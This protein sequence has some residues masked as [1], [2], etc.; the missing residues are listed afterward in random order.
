MMKKERV[1]R[2]VFFFTL[3]VLFMCAAVSC[4]E[5]YNPS[6]HES[7]PSPP[8]IVGVEPAD[9]SEN[10]SLSVSITVEFS[11]SVDPVTVH[12]STVMLEDADGKTVAVELEL[13]SGNSV[14]TL[15]PEDTLRER[16][17]YYLV[18]TRQITDISGI[19]LDVNGKDSIFVSGFTTRYSEPEVLSVN[20]SDGAEISVNDMKEASVVFSEQ[21]DAESINEGNIYI[22]DV[23]GEVSYDEQNQR[24][25]FT[26]EE[27]LIPHREYIIF[28]SREVEDLDG[29][30]MGEDIIT[31]FTTTE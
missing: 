28:V 13:S 27:S 23:Q 21:M 19:P 14:L 11:E 3:S 29:M 4:A 1:M 6:E 25:V 16:S 20:P 5:P 9:G 18:V 12:G 7:D 22:S 30:P 17:E 15:T 8:Q 2:R 31:T 24:A 26:P 10:I